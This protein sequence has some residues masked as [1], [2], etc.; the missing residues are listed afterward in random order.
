MARSDIGE[1]EVADAVL[2]EPFVEQG[3]VGAERRSSGADGRPGRGCAWR[4]G[5]ARQS[6]WLQRLGLSGPSDGGGGALGERGGCHGR[7][8]GRR[9]LLVRWRGWAL[10]AQIRHRRGRGRL[11]HSGR[12]CSVGME[13]KLLGSEAVWGRFRGSGVGP[14]GPGRPGWPGNGIGWELRPD[15]K[16]D[17]AFKKKNA[18]ALESLQ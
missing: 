5:A 16:R 13:H 3:V 1:V 10:W 14:E 17:Q 8:R 15:S 11:A 18:T 9:V 12:F 6:G 4:W 7:W 2:G